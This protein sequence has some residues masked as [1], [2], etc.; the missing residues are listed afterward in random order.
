MQ[1]RERSETSDGTDLRYS[2]LAAAG[3]LGA[4]L[5][6]RYLPTMY[7]AAIDPNDQ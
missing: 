4:P 3:P 5:G 6:G 1:E 2:L 7:H